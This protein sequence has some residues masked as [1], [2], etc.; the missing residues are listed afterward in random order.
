MTEPSDRAIPKSTTDE[1]MALLLAVEAMGVPKKVVAQKL[2]VSPSAVTELYAGRRKLS[3]KEGMV[4]A[5][6]VNQTVRGADDR[7][8]PVIGMAGAGNWEEAIEHTTEYVPVPGQ[9]D[10]SG[11]FLVEVKGQ[12][13]NLLI[14]EGSLAIIDPDERG[15]YAGKL[16]LLLNDDGEATI[17][18]YRVDPS[19]FEPVSSDPSF[20]PF[21]LGDANFRVVGRVTGAMQRF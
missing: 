9:L 20:K 21:N 15:L 13:L 17:K 14:P 11:K 2:L 3:Y 6:L 5:K 7:E 1:S 12:S 10:V 4:L 18:R 16:Y 8:L 19:R